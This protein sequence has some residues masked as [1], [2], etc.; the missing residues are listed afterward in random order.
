[1][2]PVMH[3]YFEISEGAE[4]KLLIR[5]VGRNGGKILPTRLR[6]K[7]PK[8]LVCCS[9]PIL[10]LEALLLC[11]ILSSFPPQCSAPSLQSCA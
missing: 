7:I 4:E 11:P 8:P 9:S 6:L 10:S 5:R 1:M 2:V 3:F